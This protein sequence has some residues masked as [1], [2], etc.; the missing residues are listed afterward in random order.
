ML[1]GEAWKVKLYPVRGSEQDGIRPSLIVSDKTQ[2]TVTKV[3]VL[4]PS[5]V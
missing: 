1:V 4:Q 3:V 2:A 5:P